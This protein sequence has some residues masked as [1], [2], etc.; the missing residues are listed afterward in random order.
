[1]TKRLILLVL[2][3]ALLPDTARSQAAESPVDHMTA[4]SDRE[5]ALRK[6]YLSYI[7]TVAHGRSARK[8][9]RRRAEV[10]K[11]IQA[12]LRDGARLRPYKGDVSLRNAYLEYWNVLLHVFK[13]DYQKIV[14]MEE[15][16]ERSY[17]EMEAYLLLQEKIDEK[18]SASYDVVGDT[19]RLFAATHNVR[20]VTGSASKLDLKLKAAGEVNHYVNQLFLI[21]FKSTVQETKLVEALNKGDLGSV[22]QLR[23][24]VLQFSNE[25]LSR[26]DT[27][28]TYKGD[29]SLI[30]T[31]RKVL[32]FQREEAEARIP[33]LMDFH[34][35]AGEFQKIK[36][37][38][39]AIPASKRTQKDVDHYNN[40]VNDFNRR[41]P[42]YN[43]NSEAL[44]DAR[45]KT[46]AGWETVRK[47]FLDQHTPYN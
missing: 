1:M 23:S 24:A 33:P 26:L 34:I 5:D 44:F 36:D 19:Y 41:I 28:R 20:L 10:I 37:A 2:L 25:G 45:S 46:M 27:V 22:E 4:L 12:N 17:D 43:K 6:K 8:M 38:F 7:S 3:S 35:K 14:D 11:E 29:G 47:R 42:E 18:L 9:E 39:E 13:E 15:V 21:Y 31:C 30:S 16:I 40:A 32:E